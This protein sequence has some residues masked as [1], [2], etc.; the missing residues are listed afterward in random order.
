MKR[1]SRAQKLTKTN[2]KVIPDDKT[3]IYKIK[4]D[5]GEN[6]YTGIAGRYR[7]QAR[8]LEHKEIK[9]EKI[10]G[11]TRFQYMQVKD[12]KVA[13]LT[14]KQIIGKEKPRYNVKHK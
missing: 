6:L 9:S 12:K 11:G 5:K 7:G 13:D 3:I 2:I 4:N 1:F 14:E 8:L 10:P